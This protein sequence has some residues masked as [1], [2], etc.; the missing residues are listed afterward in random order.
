MYIFQQELARKPTW[1]RES[2]GKLVANEMILARL[3]HLQINFT[4]SSC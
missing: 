3:A 2:A 1:R 4:V